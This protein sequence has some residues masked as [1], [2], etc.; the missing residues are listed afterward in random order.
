WNQVGENPPAPALA[1]VADRLY[2]LWITPH[3]VVKAAMKHN[4]TVQEQTEGGKKMTTISFTMPGQFKVKA[5]VNDK[6]LV[7]KADSWNT[8]PVLGDMLTE[9]TYADYKDFG[10]VQ[11][12]TKIPQKAGGFPTLELT[13]SEVK[14]NAPVDIPAPDNV[15]QASVKVDTDKVAD[16]VWFLTG[17][18]HKRV[19]GAMNDHR[20]VIEGPQ[21]DA[22]ATA[23]IAEVKKTVPNKP[24]K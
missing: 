6:N 24:I 13:V 16:G 19:L 5:L 3:G 23:V 21:D 4:A 15:R 17:G 18:T 12:P 2:Q 20:V 7:E 10:G 22:R 11:F 8:N 9:T 14:P 1:A